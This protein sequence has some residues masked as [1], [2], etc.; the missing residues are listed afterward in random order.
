MILH[1]YRCGSWLAEFERRRML[2]FLAERFLV[3]LVPDTEDQSLEES[4]TAQGCRQFQDAQPEA[5]AGQKQAQDAQNTAVCKVLL[6]VLLVHK[7]YCFR[8]KSL[9][10]QKILQNIQCL[11]LCGFQIVIDHHLVE[12]IGETQFKFSLCDAV[13]N[14]F[15]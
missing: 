4:Q 7:S 13:F 2:L 3:S 15:R 11:L 10:V 6:D 12:L 5:Y 8:V 14:Y 9:F 1:R